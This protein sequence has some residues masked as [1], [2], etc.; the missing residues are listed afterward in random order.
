MALDKSK[1]K[2]YLLCMAIFVVGMLSVSITNIFGGYYCSVAA[3]EMILYT[4]IVYNMFDK[5]IHS[6]ENVI[7]LVMVSVIT[8]LELVFFIINDI[9]GVDVYVKGDL[10]FLGVCVIISQL[11]SIFAIAYSSVYFV[12]DLNKSHVEL[13]DEKDSCLDCEK[14][15]D[16]EETSNHNEG[17]KT[18]I[19][20]EEKTEIKSIKEN[21]I[22]VKTPF[23]E[24]EN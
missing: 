1:I 8:A 2:N 20:R 13:V 15:D 11:L 23:M 24:E 22:E 19:D 16:F 9:F 12:L 5:K 4:I 21:N 17:L 14:S 6:K 7:S 10:N 3:V 18:E